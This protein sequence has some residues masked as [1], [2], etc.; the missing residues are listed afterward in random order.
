MICTKNRKSLFW[1]VGTI[2][3]RQQKESK[4]TEIGE[5]IDSEIS[6]LSDI[7]EYIAIDKYVIM[8]N[9]VHMIIMIHGGRPEVAPT[10]SRVIQQFKGAVSKQAGFP[11][12]QKS[13]YDHIIRDENDYLEI[14]DYID[15]NP[16]KWAENRYNV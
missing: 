10:L 12:W 5:I 1:S 13:F 7:Y 16:A 9:H 2:F 3:D 8:P 14:W 11:V 4:L 6:R 15:T